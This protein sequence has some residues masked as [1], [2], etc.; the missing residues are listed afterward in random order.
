MRKIFLINTPQLRDPDRYEGTIGSGTYCS[1]NDNQTMRWHR[2]GTLP[3][4]SSRRRSRFSINFWISELALFRHPVIVT[5]YTKK[6]TKPKNKIY[7]TSFPYLDYSFL[8]CLAY[9]SIFLFFF[10]DF[11]KHIEKY[12]KVCI[13]HAK[14]YMCLVKKKRK[15]KID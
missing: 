11:T 14:S 3:I 10:L 6:V 9:F 5:L 12:T 4:L 7:H 8:F 1:I 15:E 13:A 2:L